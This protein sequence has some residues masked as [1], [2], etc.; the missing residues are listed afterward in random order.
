MVEVKHK[1]LDKSIEV[2]RIIGSYTHKEPGP[3][4]IFTGGTHGNE[5]SSV[6]ALKQIFD[7]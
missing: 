2:D 5:T 4:V 6:F 3:T 1:K 7:T